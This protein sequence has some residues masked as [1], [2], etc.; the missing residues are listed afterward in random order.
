M[1]VEA[2]T[3]S[4][5]GPCAS[6]VSAFPPRPR[7]Q[8]EP[9]AHAWPEPPGHRGDEHQARDGVAEHVGEVGMERQGGH[10]LAS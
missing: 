1:A 6:A 2:P 4:D 7:Q 8:H 9:R 5:D 3:E 10:Q